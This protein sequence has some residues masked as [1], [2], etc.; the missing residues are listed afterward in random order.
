[1]DVPRILLAVHQSYEFGVN[2][3]SKSDACPDGPVL[4]YEPPRIFKPC[5]GPAVSDE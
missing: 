2:E 4:D 5:D 3:P 1:M